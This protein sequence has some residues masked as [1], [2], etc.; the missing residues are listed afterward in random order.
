MIVCLLFETLSVKIQALLKGLIW[1]R[2]E[3]YYSFAVEMNKASA[4]LVPVAGRLNQCSYLLAFSLP[5]GPHS[6]GQDDGSQD[7]AST[8]SLLDS[9]EREP[10]KFLGLIIFGTSLP[11]NQSLWAE[12]ARVRFP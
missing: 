10:R 4:R 12:S 6:L 2:C 11:L 7:Q 9:R 5:F 3:E 8:V 1:H